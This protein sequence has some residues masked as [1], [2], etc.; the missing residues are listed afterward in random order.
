MKK[1]LTVMTMV[2]ALALSAMTIAFASSDRV[3]G[4]VAWTNPQNLEQSASFVAMTGPKG[5][6]RG[7]VEVWREDYGTFYGT[8]TCVAQDGNS[9][10][11][12]GYMDEAA[13]DATAYTGYFQIRVTDN[14][15]GGSVEPRDKIN[16]ARSATS[17]GCAEVVAATSEVHTGNLVVHG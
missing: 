14:G 10:V 4:D 8:V 16:V 1:T 12:A 17:L 6:T 3:T 11:F 2:I 7:E 13:S 15:P 9:A 5:E